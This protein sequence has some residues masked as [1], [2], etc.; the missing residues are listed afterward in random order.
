MNNSSHSSRFIRQVFAY[1]YATHLLFGLAAVLNTPGF[2]F[3]FYYP[4]QIHLVIIDPSVD[5][6]VWVASIGC[7]SIAAIWCSRNTRKP[8]IS[9]G[10]AALAITMDMAMLLGSLR[11]S[12]NFVIVYVLFVFGSAVIVPLVLLST[13]P[14]AM[15][16]RSFIFFLVYLASIGIASATHYVVAAFDPT[17]QVGVF[18]SQIELQL[19]FAPYAT[20][21]WLCL[22][23]LFSWAWV[24]ITMFALRKGGLIHHSDQTPPNQV[25]LTYEPGNRRRFMDWLDPRILVALAVGAFVGYYPYFHNPG[26]LVGT[27]A[28]WRYYDPLLRV[29]AGGFA[30]ALKERYPVMLVLLYAMQRLLNI[31]PYIV[32]QFVPL[33]LVLA[34][35]LSA[36]WFLAPNDNA[37]GLIIFLL[38]SFSFASTM[39]MFSSILANWAALV[40][41]F[42]FA[43]Y[44]S[45]KKKQSLGFLGFIITLLL[46]TMFLFI[47]PW[48]WGLFSA[49]IV[50]AAVVYLVKGRGNRRLG[51]LLVSIISLDVI[52]ALVS[53]ILLPGSQ[54]WRELDALQLYASALRPERLFLF[55]DALVW[56]T[57]T[58]GL[59][60]S[61]VSIAVSI[62]GVF[63]LMRPSTTPWRRRFILAW[64][65]V[66]AMSSILAAPIGFNPSHPESSETQLWRVLFL[67]PFQLTAPFGI[68]WLARLERSR[69]SEMATGAEGIFQKIWIPLVFAGGVVSAWAPGPLRLLTLF[70]V[71]PALT[72]AVLEKSHGKETELMGKIL[73]TTFMVLM[74]DLATR[75]LS[76]LLV[77]PHNYNPT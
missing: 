75:A 18:D 44:V 30:Q 50:L 46:S 52:M 16:T 66:S 34:M 60:F 36:W 9:I 57:R 53:L 29:N 15:F 49:S 21:P 2:K 71:L 76:Q 24:P 37:F 7:S 70:L 54:G 26:W 77:D 10:V 41:W 73:L 56:I 1:A 62:V 4:R 74:F 45:S 59:F 20:V 63:C 28:L 12:I 11:G 17:T 67:T 55:W 25:A 65:C 8:V 68:V 38:S 48:T 6:L 42:A 72:M 14:N 23:F 33:F 58:F 27:D 61:P 35:G 13:T 5:V 19:T 39:G 69:I 51:F 22:A 43:A 47:H 40:V 32:I 64:L 31:S 3:L